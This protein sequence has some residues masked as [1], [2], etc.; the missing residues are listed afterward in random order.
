MPRSGEPVTRP[1]RLG[2][3]GLGGATTLMLPSLTLHPGIRIIAGADSRF[4]ARERFA[5]DFGAPA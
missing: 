5:R 3:I 4:D 2:L 1:L